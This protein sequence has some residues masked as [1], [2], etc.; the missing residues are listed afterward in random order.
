MNQANRTSPARSAPRPRLR[1][2]HIGTGQSDQE[3]IDQF[4]VRQGEFERIMEVLEGNIDVDSCQHLLLVA[5]RG[6]GKTTL[7]VR[8][9]AELRTNTDLADRLLAVRLMEEGATPCLVGLR[10]SLARRSS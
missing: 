4:V 10:Q 8:V 7:L 6:R 5:P 1:K 9:I 3:I 2:F